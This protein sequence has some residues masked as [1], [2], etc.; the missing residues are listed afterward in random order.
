ME[1]G[2]GTL[3]GFDYGRRRIGVAVANT[4]T[5]SARPLLTLETSAGGPD[6][7]GIRAL[8]DEWR[9]TRLVVGV[10]YNDAAPGAEIAAE[11][12][13]FARRLHGRFNLPVDTVDERLSSA[14][15][16]DRL[17][18]ARRAGRRGAIEKKDIDS[19]AAAVILQDWLDNHP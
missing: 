14:E 13:R 5:R 6:W 3:L 7:A 10:P 8:L 16:H 4:L 17:R 19:A 15:A 9:P 18:T 12:L 2:G 11:A 1:S